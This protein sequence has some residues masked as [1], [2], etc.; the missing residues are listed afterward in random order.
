MALYVVRKV[1]AWLAGPGFCVA[2]VVQPRGRPEGEGR[3]DFVF[4]HGGHLVA[5]PVH[6]RGFLLVELKVRQVGADGRGFR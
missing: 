2:A 1:H 4:K 6:C 3:R 5:G